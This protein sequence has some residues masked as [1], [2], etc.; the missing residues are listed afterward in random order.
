MPDDL[1]RRQLMSTSHHFSHPEKNLKMNR[2]FPPLHTTSQ[3]Y[4]FVSVCVTYSYPLPPPPTYSI[5][6]FLTRIKKRIATTT[7]CCWGCCETNNFGL[8]HFASMCHRCDL[9]TNFFFRTPDP[10][11]KAK[12][13]LQLMRVRDVSEWLSSAEHPAKQ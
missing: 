7:D 2:F 6:D 11:Y 13:I 8:M 3:N 1:N 4:A 5:Q 12:Y 10:T 9:N